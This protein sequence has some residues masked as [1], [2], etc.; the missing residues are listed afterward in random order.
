VSG[1]WQAVALAAVLAGC[2]PV[3]V[4]HEVEPIYVTVDVN[5]RVQK[6]LQEFFDYEE[7]R[8]PEDAVPPTEEERP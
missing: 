3:T 4:K 1:R 8:S 2:A 6:R 5:I 7:D